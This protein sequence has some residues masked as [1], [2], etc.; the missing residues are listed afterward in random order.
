[1][2]KRW[3]DATGT[4][5][6]RANMPPHNHTVPSSATSLMLPRCAADGTSRLTTVDALRLTTADASCDGTE[7]VL[8]KSSVWMLSVRS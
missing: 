6:R 1:M 2:P 8:P 5:G 7:R 3:R 4:G